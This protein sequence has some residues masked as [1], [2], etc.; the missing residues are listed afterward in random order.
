MQKQ[1]NQNLAVVFV[2]R[3][4]L[5]VAIQERKPPELIVSVKMNKKQDKLYNCMNQT[6]FW[7]VYL[8]I[9]TFAGLY[10]CTQA[11]I[12]IDQGPIRIQFPHLWMT[13]KSVYNKIHKI[14]ICKD[15]YLNVISCKIHAKVNIKIGREAVCCTSKTIFELYKTQ[16]KLQKLQTGVTCTLAKPKDRL[17][18]PD[19]NPTCREKMSLSWTL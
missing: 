16:T 9:F 14:Y 12:T 1:N 8:Q 13:Q 17:N 11:R 3:P 5:P 19:L 10:C 15:A 4:F 18:I 6:S 7:K 2:N